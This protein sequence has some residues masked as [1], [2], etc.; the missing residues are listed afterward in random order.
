MNSISI[1]TVSELL[2]Q[3]FRL[4][5]RVSL[6]G[7]GAFVAQ[8]QPATF[9]DDGKRLTPPSKKIIFRTNEVWNDGYLEEALAAKENKPKEEIKRILGSFLQNLAFDADNGK[10]ILFKDL[11]SLSKNPDGTYR[12]DML[13]GVNLLPESFGLLELEV[14]P[15]P[16]SGATKP[17]VTATPLIPTI[18]PP[19]TITPLSVT[20]KPVATTPAYV[21]PKP[22]VATSASAS[23][24]AE[25]KS[26]PE[27]ETW[28]EP[29]H[30]SALGVVCWSLLGLVVALV[31]AFFV[32]KEQ[33]STLYD[34]HY[35]TPEERELLKDYETK[36]R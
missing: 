33:L 8:Q 25:P 2:L 22:I 4:H 3:L 18:K 15:I 20:P 11:G 31:V 30:K 12:F 28:A 10:R 24:G 9:S 7:W 13:P 1:S 17:F 32:F 21:P 19:E 23:F 35:Y 34:E 5:N 29:P 36:N 14:T 27:A 6:P 16:A 26:V